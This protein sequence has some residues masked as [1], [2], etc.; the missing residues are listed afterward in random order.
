MA[1]IA[2]EK[3]CS[4]VLEWMKENDLTFWQL[5]T[6]INYTNGTRLK[7]AIKDRKVGLTIDVQMR[8]EKLMS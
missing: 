7:E 8:I 6:R 1:K 4:M 3:F 2:S 5:G